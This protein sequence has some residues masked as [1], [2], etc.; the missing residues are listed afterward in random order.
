L[1]R[2]LLKLAIGYPDRASE[3]RILTDSAQPPPH[4][5]NWLRS[6]MRLRSSRFRIRRPTIRLDTSL[7]DYILDLVETSRHHEQLHLGVSP[8]GAL[9]LSQASQAAALL[10][11]PRLCHAG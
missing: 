8:R 11:G 5:M 3:H 6:P 1:D 4:W 10:G 2:F 7:V 9:A